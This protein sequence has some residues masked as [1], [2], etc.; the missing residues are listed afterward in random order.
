MPKKRSKNNDV[1]NKNLKKR[2]NPG[3]SNAATNVG[4]TAPGK[5]P[6]KNSNFRT[7]A[8]IKLLNM[9]NEKPNEEQ[10]NKVKDGPARIEPDRK[11]YGNVRT[12]DQKNLEK[13]RVEMATH[14][15]DPYQVLQKAKKL[16][17]SLIK[18]PTQKAKVN[19]LDFEKFDDTFGKKA[20]R[21]RPK[22]TEFSM[23]GLAKMADGKCNDYKYESDIN[24][25]K[26][27]NLDKWQNM[28]LS[29]FALKDEQRDKRMEAGQSKRI[30]EELYKVLDS[31]DVVCYVL[32]AR[33]PMGTR[34]KH[35]ENHLRKHCPYKHLVFVL[36]KCD[37]VPTS[38]TKRWVT[39]L[40]KEYPTVAYRAH[41][42]KPFGRFSQLS[43]LRQYDNFH[44]DKKTV[45]VGFLGYPNVGKSSVINA[46]KAKKVCVSAP[47]PGET[48]VWQYIH[49]TKR[50]YLIDCPGVVYNMEADDD[51]ALVLKCVLRAE[52]QNDPDFYIQA[53]LDR[54][55]TVDMEN[56]YKVKGWKNAEEFLTLVAK[57]KGKLHKGGEAD[58][59]TVAKSCIYDWQR[60]IIP[61]YALP[62]NM[63]EEDVE[64]GRDEVLEE[65]P[66]AEILEDGVLS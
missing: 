47:I 45:S 60:G 16:P 20:G 36:N 13:F 2:A 28:D 52:R 46:L 1:V 41:M 62:P 65:V 66:R 14:A 57:Y 29:E 38:V 42:A 63:T 23:E 24:L 33:D 21:T 31:S 19:I 5:N 22:L 17:M 3:H 4:R 54:V 11:W 15:N 56:I 51:T 12:I 40:S 43:L 34:S 25:T 9:Y 32:D 61:F 37:L 49:L 30:W 48:K 64:A 58:L 53:M 7:N 59:M 10:R 18:E 39:E 27:S 26:E 50:I 55:K 35:I 44:K 6:T 8:Q